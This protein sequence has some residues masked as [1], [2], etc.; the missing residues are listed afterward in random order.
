[1]SALIASERQLARDQIARK[2]SIVP[3]SPSSHALS[4]RKPIQ[5]PEHKQTS[6]PD[7]VGRGR[8]PSLRLEG[9]PGARSKLQDT[10]AYPPL[11]LR[12]DRAAAYLGMSR[13]KFL[14]LVARG[15][16]PRPKVIDGIR[17]WNRLALKSA[18]SEL[19]EEPADAPSASHN[20]F[21]DIIRER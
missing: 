7:G 5:K 15:Q 6:V 3:K 2:S 12:G 8:R 16:L 11:G 19:G 18:F 13:S 4:P 21:D 14:A 10:L 20:T 1:M 9:R 17:V